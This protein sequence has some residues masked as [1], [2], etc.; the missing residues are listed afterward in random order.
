MVIWSKTAQMQLQ[1]AFHFISNESPQ[2]A[3]KIINKIID[4][5]IGLSKHPEIYPADKYK[6]NNG[7]NY[8]VF[9]IYHYRISYRILHDNI[10]IV[11]MR[12]TSMSPLVY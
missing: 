4:I 9:E 12:H 6:K 3:E 10:Y 11:R 2:N 7:G 5:S 8:R 1:K